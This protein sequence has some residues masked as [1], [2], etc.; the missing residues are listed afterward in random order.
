MAAVALVLL[1]LGVG[2]HFYKE[3]SEKVQS[4]KFSSTGFLS[5]AKG[6]LAGMYKSMLRDPDGYARLNSDTTLEAWNLYRERLARHYGFDEKQQ[7]AADKIYK[8]REGQ[9]EYFFRDQAE[10]I[11]VYFKSLES[12]QLDL[13]DPARRKVASLRSQI[14]KKAVAD[15]PPEPGP[16]YA[17]LEGLWSAYE[18]D[19]NELATQEQRSRRPLALPRPGAT[20]FGVNQVDMVLPYFDLVI[21]VCLILGLF[22]RV[23]SVAGAL[24]LCSVI[25][26]QWPGAADAAPVYPQLIEMLALLVLAATGAG[27][28]AGLDCLISKCCGKCCQRKQETRS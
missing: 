24:F 18:Q 14:G 2:W 25:G 12:K 16:W 1:R 22:T 3:G 13:A 20:R 10:E 7:A 8:R 26:S 19:L 21:G 11:D 9:L 5:N 23:A 28:Y 6:P 27:R 15:T 17:Q 4:G